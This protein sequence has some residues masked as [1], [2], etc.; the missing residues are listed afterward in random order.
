MSTIPWRLRKIKISEH[1]AEYVELNEDGVQGPP[2][3]DFC[4]G[5]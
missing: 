5:I 3:I 2:E 4:G 1:G